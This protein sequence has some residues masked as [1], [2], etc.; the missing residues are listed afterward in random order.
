MNRAD[1]MTVVV[2]L[3]V[4]VMALAWYL[5][6]LA[7][8]LNRLH[9]RVEAARLVLDNQLLQRSAAALELAGTGVLDPASATVL[10]AAATD[11]MS[12][13][14]ARSAVAATEPFARSLLA[15]RDEQMEQAESDLSRVIGATVTSG[16][17][18]AADTALLNLS[19]AC[20][21]VQ[22]ARRFHNDAVLAAQA[23]RRKR[24][25]RFAHLAGR[26]PL[27]LT[28]EFDDEIPRQLD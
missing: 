26:A 28:V 9:A 11:A 18:S 2:V 3:L 5:S 10:T 17:A 20:Q 22:M 19:T 24:V 6:A 13:I 7:S 14:E 4:L 23:V 21:R 16:E 25:V 27:P 15:D 8:R 12:A 1:V